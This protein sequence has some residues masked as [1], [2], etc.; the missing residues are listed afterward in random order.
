M[1][2]HGEKDGLYYGDVAVNGEKVGILTMEDE[3]ATDLVL[4]KEQG[5]RSRFDL[6]TWER[7]I[8]WTWR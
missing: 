1:C 8:K 7:G 4:R 3:W 2:G 6:A 5:R